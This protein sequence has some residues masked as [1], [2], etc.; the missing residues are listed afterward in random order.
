MG[1]GNIEQNMGGMDF[2]LSTAMIKSA[3]LTYNALKLKPNYV[4]FTKT[5]NYSSQP[6]R[7]TSL[8]MLIPTLPTPQIPSKTGLIPTRAC[9][10][11][12]SPRQ[13]SAR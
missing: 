3:V 5:A 11:I 1:N 8:T 4:E 9:L 7:I 13:R 10:L 6:I 12:A 2:K